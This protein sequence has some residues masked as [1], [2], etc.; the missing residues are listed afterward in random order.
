MFL[1]AV[2]VSVYAELAVAA[3]CLVGVGLLLYWLYISGGDD[4]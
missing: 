2:P 1:E 4:D 3:L